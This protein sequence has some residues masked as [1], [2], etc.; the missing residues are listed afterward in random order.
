MRYTRQNKIVELISINEIETQEKL[1]ELLKENGLEVTQATISRDIKELQLV[2]TLGPSG[3]Y[4][5]TLPEKNAKQA[6]G[7]YEKI[8][9]NTVQ[10]ACSSVNLVVVKTLAGCAN[11]AC[12]AIDSLEFPH[13]LGTIAGDNTVLIICDKQENAADLEAVFKEMLSGS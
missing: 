5:Y 2:K 6:L 11:A 4:R 13:V 1:A 10:S 9:K 7:R 3:Q 12:E 8:F